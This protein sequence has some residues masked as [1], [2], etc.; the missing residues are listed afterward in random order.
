MTYLKYSRE[1]ILL[2]QLSLRHPQKVTLG[3][4]T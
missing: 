2:I 3:N 1:I 4:D